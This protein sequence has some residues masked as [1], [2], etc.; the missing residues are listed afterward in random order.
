MI[1][2]MRP[3]LVLGMLAVVSCTVGS[4][5][6]GTTEPDPDETTTSPASIATTTTTIAEDG[7]TTTTISTT[8]TIPPANLTIESF[9]VPA[10]S[11]PHDVAPAARVLDCRS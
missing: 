9:P 5:G 8:T 10:D 1:R 2:S 4:S 7:E 3:F 6:A 11:R